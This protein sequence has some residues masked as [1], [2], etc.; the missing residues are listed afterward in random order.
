[1]VSGY[2]KSMILQKWWAEIVKYFHNKTKS[3]AI[4]RSCVQIVSLSPSESWPFSSLISANLVNKS[5]SST[6]QFLI[7]LAT[8][9]LQLYLNFARKSLHIYRKRILSKR[10]TCDR[11]Q[12]QKI[13]VEHKGICI[14]IRKKVGKI[15]KRKTTSFH[16]HQCTVERSTCSFKQPPAFVAA[17][18]FRGWFIHRA[19]KLAFPQNA[20]MLSSR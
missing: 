1:M 5:K 18:N 16:L 3:A 8:V 4:F 13:C 10:R 2:F 9:F 7:P 20:G 15:L 19:R 12:K 6:T 17:T 11:L 14:P